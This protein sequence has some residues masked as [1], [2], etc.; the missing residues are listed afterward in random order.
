MAVPTRIDRGTYWE[1]TDAQGTPGWL[2]AKEGMIS[3]S[4]FSSSE[5]DVI[6]TLVTGE[7]E[8]HS[9]ETKRHFARGHSVEAGVKR[10]LSAIPG[11][12]IRETGFMVPKSD[13]SI[14]V[15]LDGEITNK[16]G[17]TINLEVKG[18]EVMP[19]SLL[20]H[21][22]KI[23]EGVVFPVGYHDHINKKHYMQMQMGMAVTGRKMSAYIVDCP[24]A[25][26]T[27]EGLV[28]FDE[29]YWNEE[30]KRI[31]DLRDTQIIPLKK[32]YRSVKEGKAVE[33]VSLGIKT[34]YLALR[35]A[36][37]A[38]GDEGYKKAVAYVERIVRSPT[39]REWDEYFMGARGVEM[40]ERGG[41][42]ERKR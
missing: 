2:E 37:S 15:S 21:M 4:L 38:Y 31:C 17:H 19:L 42:V 35:I 13:P 23:K 5:D 3:P 22:Q 29:K 36:Q 1:Y 10:R 33:V 40:A 39:V 24:A 7:R 18:P 6:F 30:Y 41:G 14:G 27:Y 8:E 26:Q 12:V 20:N 34:C 9:A 16:D 32:W 25:N 11:V 28:F